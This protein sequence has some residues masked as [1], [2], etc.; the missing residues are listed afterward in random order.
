MMLATCW[1]FIMA[2]KQVELE[3]V[4]ATKHTW[5]YGVPGDPVEGE[6]P[7]VSTVYVAKEA[8]PQVPPPVVKLTVEWKE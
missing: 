4:K 5:V 3:L 1:R 8:M 7:V 2:T 6:K